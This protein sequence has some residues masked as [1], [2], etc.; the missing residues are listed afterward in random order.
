MMID[1]PAPN[2]DWETI[3]EFARSFNGYQFVKGGPVELS[4][5]WDRIAED[6]NKA[7]MDELQACLFFLQRAG[8]FCGDEGSVDDLEQARMILTLMKEKQ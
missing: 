6:P 8:R 1:I 7:S 5:L 3:A 4:S 2:S